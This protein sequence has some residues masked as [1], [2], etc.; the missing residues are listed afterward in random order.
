MKDLGVSLPAHAHPPHRVRLS[1][2]AVLVRITAHRP[3]ESRLR[4]A[5]SLRVPQV[6]PVAG[7]PLPSVTHDQPVPILVLP[8]ALP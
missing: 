6:R 3:A 1:A 5:S 4:R 8:T 7:P 2:V